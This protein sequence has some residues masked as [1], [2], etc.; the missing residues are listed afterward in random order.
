MSTKAQFWISWGAAIMAL[1]TAAKTSWELYTLAW[2]VG[3]TPQENVRVALIWF[4]LF[5]LFFLVA[6]AIRELE[7][8]KMK[9]A[10]P[11]MKV[12]NAYIDRRYVLLRK[13]QEQPGDLFAYSPE[14]GSSYRLAYESSETYGGTS[15]Y[16]RFPPHTQV[17][18]YLFAHVQF[19]NEPKISVENATA[20]RVWAD[21]TF[22][23]SNKE[24]VFNN[25]KGRWGDKNQPQRLDLHQI[26]K[27]LIQVDFSPNELEW[28]LDIAMRHETE[29]I[30]FVFN[31]DSY[32]FDEFRREDLALREKKYFVKV[33][34]KGIGLKPGGVPFCF[35]LYIGEKFDDFKIEKIDCF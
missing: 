19:V 26:K 28:E 33:I 12:K 20:K 15:S 4:G 7:I 21:I 14:T 31:N 16:R 17:E 6:I 1:I 24:S 10:K 9:N 5:V 23:N 25:I 13:F 29:K 2:D 27:D 22:Y 30:G 8:Q 11:I 18:N 35:E 34:L 32:E 3:K